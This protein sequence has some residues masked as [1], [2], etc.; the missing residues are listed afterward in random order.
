MHFFTKLICLYCMNLDYYNEY[1]IQCT[2][3]YGAVIIK[4]SWWKNLQFDEYF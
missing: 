2:E 1:S 3:I 4:M